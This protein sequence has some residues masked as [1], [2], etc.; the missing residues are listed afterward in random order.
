MGQQLVNESE[1]FSVKTAK[2]STSGPSSSSLLS[3]AS[4]KSKSDF[5]QSSVQT[6]IARKL[7]VAPGVSVYNEIVSTVFPIT[8][9]WSCRC[10]SR[11]ML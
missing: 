10:L 1:P 4:T 7:E 5:G 6:R 3:G 2:G 8:S 11:S 9:H